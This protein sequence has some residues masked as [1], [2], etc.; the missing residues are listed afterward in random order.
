MT[1]WTYQTVYFTFGFDSKKKVWVC[2]CGNETYE[3]VEAVLNVLG[4]DGWELVGVV[5][6]IVSGPGY[7]YEQYRAFFKKLVTS[8]APLRG[9]FGE[10]R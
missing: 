4:S 3:S 1:S 6:N 2:T 9:G 8:K 10:H 5:G 7:D